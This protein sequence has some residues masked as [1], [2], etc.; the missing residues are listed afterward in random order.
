MK[1]S[2]LDCLK[3]I[4]GGN[5]L[6]F[7][8]SVIILGIIG[9]PALAQTSTKSILFEQTSESADIEQGSSQS[10]LEYISTSDNTPVSAKLSAV[11]NVGSIPTWLTVNGKFLNGISY[12]TGS[13]I[14]FDFDA[15]NLSVGTYYATVTASASGY[16]NAVLDIKMSVVAG[17]SGTLANFKVNFQDSATKTPVGWLRDFGQPFGQRTSASQGSGNLYGWI[18]RSDKTLLDLTK[19]GRKRTSPSDT[20]LATLMHMQA[21]DLSTFS[22]TRIEGIWQAQVANGNYE[23]TVSVGDGTQTDS[24]HSINVEGI[25]AILGFVPTTTVRFKS[26]KVIVS[27]SDGYLTVDAAGGT[28]TK[29]NWI[30]IK[31]YMGKRPSVV[32]VNPDNSSVNVSENT[33]ISTSVLKLP[34]SGINNAT[35]TTNNVYLTDEGTGNLIPSNVNGTGGG[36]A[37]TLV[38]ASPL[39]LG[40]TYRFTITSGVKDLS[41]SSFIPYSSTFTTGSTAVNEST[42][43]EFDQID[44]PNAVGQHSSLTVGPDGKL[45]ALTIDGIIKRFT[46]NPDGTLGTPQL[47]YSLQDEYGTRS[48][49]SATNLV[50]WVT[51]STFLFLGAPDWDG[52]L[53]RL[54]GPNLETVQDVLI[55]L[56]RSKKDHLTNSIAFGPDRALYFTQ[57]STSAMGRADQTW[58]NRNEHLL[59]AAV[60]RLDVS[61]LGPLPLDVK[62]TDGGGT[63]NPYNANAPL[64]I[65]A[66]GIRNA[67][68]LVWHSNGS[69]YAAANG[70]AAGGNTPASVSGTLRPDGTTYNGPVIPALTNVQQTQKDFLFRVVKGGY[71]GHPNPTRGE[72]VMNG[73]NPTDLIDPAQVNGYPSG[74]APDPNYR[75]YAYDFKTNASPNGSIEYKSNTF[76][77]ALKGKLLIVR[78]SQHD[79]IIALTPGGPNN[80]IISATEG[81][82]I[83][84]FSGFND[85][86]ELTEDTTKGNIYLSNY[87]GDGKIVLLR[88]RTTIQQVNIKTLSPI[89]DAFVRN[90]SYAGK[91]YGSDTSLIVKS[92]ASS[93]YSRATYLKFR[94]DS[95]SKVN[96]AV[97]RVYG[98][99]TENFSAIKISAFGLN[100]D[101]WTEK[102]ITWSNA[103]APEAPSLSTT[104]VTDQLKYY[105]F[106][107]TD[108]VKSQFS[109]DSIVSLVIKDT[110]N[111]NKNLSFNSKENSSFP[112]QLLITT[113]TVTQSFATSNTVSP[114]ADASVRNGSYAGNNYGSDTTLL[115]KS[116]TVSG[117]SRSTYLKFSL[118]NISKV[119]LAKLRLYGRN[120]ENS[121]IINISAFGVANDSWTESGI[122][123]SNAPAASTAALSSAGVNDQAKYYDFDVSGFVKSEFAG[124]KTVSFLIKD[125]SN[126][127]KTL[128]FNSKENSMY[129][130]QLIITPDSSAT[131]YMARSIRKTSAAQTTPK[132]PSCDDP[133]DEVIPAESTVLPL[134]LANNVEKPKVYPNPLHKK[135][136]IQFPVKYTG[137]YALQI[138]DAVG[139]TF[140]IGKYQLKHGGSTIEVNISN[141][142]LKPGVYFLKVI[143][144]AKTELIKLI[145]Q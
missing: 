31:P 111:Q 45:Y 83:P 70:S 56:P 78:Y 134:A 62:T 54:S 64:T 21:S 107:V 103:P 135:F 105:E 61:K 127:N 4:S 5:I 23:V 131:S 26:A 123:N 41:D 14:S 110:A 67:Y 79:D 15:T 128:T 53:S 66:S 55:N 36:D 9:F 145:V 33:S 1:K 87:G 75:G 34:N 28:N 81:Y 115:V 137:N 117:Y 42:K 37:I 48:R 39:Q 101:S 51:H 90:G 144:D 130:P 141:L 32:S 126:Q 46:I 76:N 20:L 80:D 138:V 104:G 72:Y 99:N 3:K 19:N 71:Y 118:A 140:E 143:S 113:D 92:S 96:K 38:P 22:G 125:P 133:A 65:Y 106:D 35:I 89:A 58:G 122:T 40:T 43:A 57:A 29:I 10:L 91:N 94:L 25:N 124:D 109:G 73:G 97:L 59:N 132:R 30:I 12:T 82:Q 95:I 44:L 121:S 8:F 120:T 24:R 139:K 84:G 98:K 100:N 142:S 11:D 60:L 88:P 7:C 119:S 129:P 108:F 116:S 114:T 50:A 86:L 13:E 52:K 63:Y 74:T 102:G 77:G 17:S 49:S 85:P 47:I 112:P 2:T 136:N 69:L 93:G 27:V 16:N 18:K 68:D 6:K